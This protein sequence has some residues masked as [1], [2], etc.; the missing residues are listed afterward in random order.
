MTERTEPGLGIE[1]T[2]VHPASAV[3]S[4]DGNLSNEDAN[5]HMWLVALVSPAGA[6][7]VLASYI[8]QTEITIQELVD[9]LSTDEAGQP[10][11]NYP[12]Y[13]LPPLTEEPQS[14]SGLAGTA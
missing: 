13:Y 6:S 4:A 10:V 8:R 3:R 14:F 9:C 11:E 7:Q 12:P 1:P 5:D 2:D